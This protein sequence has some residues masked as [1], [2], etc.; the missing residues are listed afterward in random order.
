MEE[1]QIIEEEITTNEVIEEIPQ[2][3]VEED[4]EEVIEENNQN[5][6][7][8]EI[9]IEYVKQQLEKEIEEKEEVT[10][11]YNDISINDNNL[12]SDPDTQSVDPVITDIYD[13]VSL[14]TGYIEEYNRDNTLQSDINDISLSNQLTILLFITILFTAVLNF[15][16]RIF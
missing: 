11:E 16:R 13:E 8:N 12:R 1:N 7:E 2:E 10:D 15:S 14:L 3:I 9:L 4:P 5:E 6:D